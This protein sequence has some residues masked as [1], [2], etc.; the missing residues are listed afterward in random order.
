MTATPLEPLAVLPVAQAREEFSKVV[1]RFREEG[2]SAQPVVFGSHRKPEAVTIPY[3][4]FQALLPAMEDILL[5]GTIRERLDQ[6]DLSWEQVLAEVG[7]T[8]E[9]VDAVNLDG[10]IVEGA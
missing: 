5:A 6:P 7:V 10:Y 2:I 1:R 8:Q 9:D 3:A 4:M